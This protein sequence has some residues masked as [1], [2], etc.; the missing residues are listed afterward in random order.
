MYRKLTRREAWQ[1]T[2]LSVLCRAGA[3]R[4][5]R[6]ENLQLTEGPEYVHCPSFSCVP[7]LTF[8]MK[9]QRNV[10]VDLGE[11]E[12]G[13]DFLGSNVG[14]ESPLKKLQM[15]Q[16]MSTPLVIGDSNGTLGEKT[17]EHL[18]RS[19]QLPPTFSRLPTTPGHHP[20]RFTVKGCLGLPNLVQLAAD[21]LNFRSPHTGRKIQILQGPRDGG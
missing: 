15:F 9:E 1:S 7:S 16:L 11:K 10:P 8:A 20:S 5:W 13:V 12:E 3:N 14:P 21:N 18:Q 2:L 17:K 6:K 19:P 4:N